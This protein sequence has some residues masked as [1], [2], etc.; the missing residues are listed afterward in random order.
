MKKIY[1]RKLVRD[2][3]PKRIKESNGDYEVKILSEPDF[4]K[5]IL[6]KV[7]EEASGLSKA[8]AKE[9]IIAEM[10]DLLD[11]LEEVRKSFRVTSNELKKSRAREM[12]RKGGFKKRI[13]LVW[14][15]DTGYKS[16]EKKGKK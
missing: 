16:N 11:V 12:E 13:Y 2:R 3:I 8:T 7:E 5:E 14:A 6:K 1:Y 15:E 9:E 4:R 10:G